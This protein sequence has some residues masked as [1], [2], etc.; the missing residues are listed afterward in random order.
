MRQHKAKRPRKQG[1][2]DDGL[3]ELDSE[4]FTLMHLG[5]ESKVEVAS[6]ED[7]HTEDL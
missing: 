4:T 3:E 1:E 2:A 7:I 6:W 5:K